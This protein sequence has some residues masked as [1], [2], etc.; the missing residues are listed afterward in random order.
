VITVRVG[1][2][3]DALHVGGI[4]LFGSSFGNYPQDLTLRLEYAPGQRT[5][6]NRP[7]AAIVSST[8]AAMK[9][10]MRQQLNGDQPARS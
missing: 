9:G 10:G 2:K 5:T 7:V 8:G 6:R 3:A 4:N 1:V